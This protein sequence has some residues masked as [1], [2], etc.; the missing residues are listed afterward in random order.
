MRIARKLLILAILAILIIAGTVIIYSLNQ[1]GSSSNEVDS[2]PVAVKESVNVAAEPDHVK[3][4]YFHRTDRCVSCNNAE[5]Y[6]RETLD[7]YYAD[8]IQSGQLSMQ[9][10]DYQKDQAMTEEYNVKVQGLKVVSTRG[11]QTNTKDVP[12]IWSYVG[13]KD[14]FTGFLKSVIDKELRK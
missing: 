2:K 4:L 1:P 3:L 12:E 9:S 7:K 5:Q 11:G 14:A 6:I 10:I 13:D 8:E